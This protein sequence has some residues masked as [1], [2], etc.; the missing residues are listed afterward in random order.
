M[1]SVNP[2]IITGATGAIGSHLAAMLA[3]DGVSMIFACRNLSKAQRLRHTIL[4]EYPRAQIEIIELD[5]V[6]LDSVCRFVRLLKESLGSVKVAALVNNA[7]VIATRHEPTAQGWEMNAGINYVGAWLLTALV[8]PCIMD[9]GCIVNVI[10]CTA[11][12]S[13][14]DSRFLEDARYTETCRYNR[15]KRYSQSKQALLMAT[16]EMALRFLNL[17]VSAADPGI[18]DSDMIT[19]ERWFDPLADILF[20]P[21]I[22][23]PQKGALPIYCALT[24]GTHCGKDV[25]VYRGAKGKKPLH[26]SIVQSVLPA[27]LWNRTQELLNKFLI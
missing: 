9:G 25:F 11:A 5:L 21:F 26:K 8:Q 15:L 16:K 4:E 17:R 24:D 23:S 22:K 12:L 19:M 27:L 14:I 6:S 10:S 20:R 1:R 18:V 13:G 7:G 2:I 3:K